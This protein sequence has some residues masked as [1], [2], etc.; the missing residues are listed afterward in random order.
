MLTGHP[1][2][3]SA[4][5][6]TP[7]LLLQIPEQVMQRL[8]ELVPSVRDHF[9]RFNKALYTHSPGLPCRCGDFVSQYLRVVEDASAALLKKKKWKTGVQRTESFAGAWGVPTKLLLSFFVTLSAALLK[10]KKRKTGVQRT[11][12]FA[13]AWGVPTKLLL[14]FFVAVGG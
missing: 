9:E 6:Q 3:A 2:K 4:R 14:S 8:V 7:T 12:S 10:K 11:E 13:G 5:A 1:Y